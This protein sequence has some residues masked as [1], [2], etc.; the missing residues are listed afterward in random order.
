MKDRVL[1]KGPLHYE[2]IALF[3]IYMALN[4]DAC[5]YRGLHTHRITKRHNVAGVKSHFALA[6]N[7]RFRLEFSCRRGEVQG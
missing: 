7:K 5:K 4:G 6:I 1:S 3:D 2:T